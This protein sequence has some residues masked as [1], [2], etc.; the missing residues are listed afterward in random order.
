M[1]KRTSVLLKAV[2]VVGTTCGIILSTVAAD[3]GVGIYLL[4]DM[5]RANAKWNEAAFYVAGGSKNLPVFK[6]MQWSGI[7]GSGAGVVVSLSPQKNGSAVFIRGKFKDMSEGNPLPEMKL[8][9]DGTYQLKSESHGMVTL[10]A[11]RQLTDKE[12]EQFDAEIKR[13]R[14]LHYAKKKTLQAEIVKR[15]EK[16]KL[17]YFAEQEKAKKEVEDF[18]SCIDLDIKK[19]F[20]LDRNLAGAI[21]IVLQRNVYLEDLRNA[22]LQK[23]WKQCLKIV[24]TNF[25]RRNEK[26]TEILQENV[27]ASEIFRR[28]AEYGFVEHLDNGEWDIN[29]FYKML[30]EEDENQNWVS[31]LNLANEILQHPHS[32][33]CQTTLIEYPS[34]NYLKEILDAFL[35]YRFPLEIRIIDKDKATKETTDTFLVQRQIRRINHDVNKHFEVEDLVFQEFDP[36]WIVEKNKC[37]SALGDHAKMSTFSTDFEVCYGD[38]K[39]ARPF[40]CNYFDGI[41]HGSEK[42]G[43]C[44][45]MVPC[46]VAPVKTW[47]E[48]ISKGR[49]EFTRLRDDFSSDKIR[50]SDYIRGVIDIAKRIEDAVELRFVRVDKVQEVVNLKAAQSKKMDEAAEEPGFGNIAT[51]QANDSSTTGQNIG[52]KPGVV[53]SEDVP[54]FGQTEYRNITAEEARADKNEFARIWS[55]IKPEDP[56]AASVMRNLSRLRQGMENKSL[57]K[58]YDKYAEYKCSKLL[59]DFNVAVVEAKAKKQVNERMA[60]R[61]IVV[62]TY[63]EKFLRVLRKRMDEIINSEAGQNDSKSQD[64]ES[65]FGNQRV[66]SSVCPDCGGV[67]FVKEEVPCNRCDGERVETKVKLGLNGTSRRVVSKCPNCKG[68]GTVLKKSPCRTC[69]G[70]GKIQK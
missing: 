4:E 63:V 51:Q 25:Y 36:R 24:Y 68:A 64:G 33:E 27:H 50:T 12:K 6:V 40:F 13:L 37:K 21:D 18:F 11:L 45:Q 39:N 47:E 15:I 20:Y 55:L 58:I 28:L 60:A 19:N 59:K 69:K 41:Y 52:D 66:T 61:E 70:R 35:R 46:Y 49:K 57:A 29:P 43:V 38:N 5:L 42:R 16:I 10:P 23:D 2:A 31:C 17:S 3:S 53:K 65:G 14:E 34:L 22:Q 44:L 54:K 56:S 30:Y 1:N 67:K 9:I 7:F 62:K 8:K 32:L 26:K 48:L